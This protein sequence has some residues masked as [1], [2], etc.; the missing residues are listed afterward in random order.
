MKTYDAIVIGGGPA[1]LS[2]AIYLARANRSVLVMD[3][4]DG[5]SK[6]RQLN[7]NYLGFPKGIAA[8]KLVELGRLQAQKFGAEFEDDIILDVTSRKASKGK[9]LFTLE[10]K[11]KKYYAR[12]LILATGVKDIFPS[13]PRA[14]DF[15]GT[16]IFWCMMC[17]AW[18][19]KN[20]KVVVVG[21]DT[22]AV[23]TCLKLLNYT[24][25]LLF[26]IHCEK[27]SED[28]DD[29]VM[30]ELKK[31]NIPIRYGSIKNIRGIKGKM[32]SIITESDENIRADF[33]FSKLGYSI[34]ND[35]GNMLGAT[36][37]SKGF[38]KVDKDQRTSVPFLYA[39]GDVTNDT[40]HQIVTAAHQGAVAGTSL[41]EDLLED[42]QR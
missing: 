19:V 35:I 24:K 29:K 30:K 9:K 15:I 16:S 26:L 21:I 8:R 14:E 1:G 25:D 13:F 20:K 41:D 28:I 40:S 7:E 17:D 38:I 10:G 37:E 6:G 36:I 32:K 23:K 31:R 22:A 5:R 42:F 12:G 33:I 4:G 2:A 39:A 27:G 11:R 18:K 3:R 34:Q